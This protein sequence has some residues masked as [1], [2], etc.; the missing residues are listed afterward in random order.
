M[1]A[2]KKRAGIGT[3]LIISGMIIIV[4]AFVYVGYGLWMEYRAGLAAEEAASFIPDANGQNTPDNFFDPD[5]EMPTVEINGM[6]YAG[7]LEV[8]SLS[9][10]LA[11]LSEWSYDGLNISPCIF[12][13]S[14]YRN[15]LVIAGHNYRK[16]FTGIKKLKE[17]ETVIF[18]DVI[19]NRFEYAVRESEVIDPDDADKMT[20][21]PDDSWDL[22][23]FTCT[24]G[25]SARFALRCAIV[26][27]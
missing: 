15:D 14:V 9:L 13:G 7:I 8:P 2:R 1:K 26:S 11:V 18:K 12:S 25:G 20:E 3:I 21:D 27:Q 5:M 17:N 19:G 6:K 22:T 4:S 23:L 10:K 16:H 24:S